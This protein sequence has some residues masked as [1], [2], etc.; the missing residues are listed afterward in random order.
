M[1]GA[2]LAVSIAGCLHQLTATPGPNDTLIGHGIRDGQAM[3]TTLRHKLIRVPARLVHHAGALEL[4]LPPGYSLLEAI[5]TRLR[6]LPTTPR[7]GHTAPT[8][9]EPAHP[10]RHSDHHPAPNPEITHPKINNEREDHLCL[11]L[12]DSGQRTPPATLRLIRN[13]RNWI[14]HTR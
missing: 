9:S 1:W 4:R 5:L 6:T 12:A 8:T 7:P 2:L 3:I 11:L 10:R 13:T 14:Q